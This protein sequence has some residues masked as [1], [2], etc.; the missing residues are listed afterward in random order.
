ML[1]KFLGQLT[2]NVLETGEML[3]ML[4]VLWGIPAP[5]FTIRKVLGS[6]F[7]HDLLKF[8]LIFGGAKGFEAKM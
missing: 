7:F 5:F 4:K 6:H 2:K 3:K 8:A 1:K